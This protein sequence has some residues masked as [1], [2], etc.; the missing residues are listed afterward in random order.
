MTEE[1]EPTSLVIW[2]RLNLAA[3]ESLRNGNS[4]AKRSIE[5]L[6][7]LKVL[8]DD[9]LGGTARTL[10]KDMR[11]DERPF[12]GRKINEAAIKAYVRLRG[13]N[14]PHPVTL[15]KEGYRDYI[16]AREREVARPQKPKRKNSPVQREV[17][18]AI[19]RVSD[20]DDRELLRRH[21]ELGRKAMH[22]RDSALWFVSQLHGID[23]DALRGKQLT[24]AALSELGSGLDEESR[25]LFVRL[26]RRL[27]DND[28]LWPFYL[29]YRFGRVRMDPAHPQGT[30]SDLM[31]PEELA[32]MARAAKFELPKEETES[33]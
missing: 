9:V 12:I 28:V 31:F 11:E 27:T 21:I 1:S 6:E 3:H 18:A 22:E 24:K 25:G 4:T 19:D 17:D 20:F 26:L 2:D 14:G 15:R 8:C 29:E 16:D 33:G 5:L 13:W 30:A 32:A 7:Q 10:A 23:I